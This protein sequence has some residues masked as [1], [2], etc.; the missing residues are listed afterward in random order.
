MVAA[1][2]ELAR[3]RPTAGARFLLE[4]ERAAPDGRTAA[5]RAWVITPDATWA[6][7]AALVA[8]AEPALTADGVAAPAELEAALTMIARLTARSAGAKGEDG[9]APWPQRV[10]RWRGPGRGA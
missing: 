7:A 8:G 1:S 10:L 3:L 5:Y 4:L 2:A 9:L 6:Y